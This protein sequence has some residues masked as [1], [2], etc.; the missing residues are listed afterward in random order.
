MGK[1]F[2]IYFVVGGIATLID[3][4]MYALSLMVL[5]P[6]HYLISVIVSMGFAGLFHYLA[7]KR[8][9]FQCRSRAIGRQVPIYIGVALAGLSMSMGILRILVGSIGLLPMTARV[10]TTLMMLFPN[11]LMHKYLT[12]SKKIFSDPE[13]TAG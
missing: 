8:L 11:Y 4:G 10:L 1:E 9:T 6:E 12:F 13:T 2:S 3:W 5:G 7:N